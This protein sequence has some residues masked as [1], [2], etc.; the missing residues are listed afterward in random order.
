MALVGIRDRSVNRN[1]DC[2]FNHQHDQLL[3]EGKKMWRLAGGKEAQTRLIGCS[4]ASA[5]DCRLP[6]ADL[7]HV[8][9]G[10]VVAGDDS[11]MDIWPRRPR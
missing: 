2:R 10:L 7:A 1:T 11:D 6:T 5:A 3:L 8:S 4:H 9:A